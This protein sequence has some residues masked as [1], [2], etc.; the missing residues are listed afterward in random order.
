MDKLHTTAEEALT[1]AR[2]AVREAERDLLREAASPVEAAILLKARAYKA[3]CK[4]EEEA[5]RAFTA[6]RQRLST[7]RR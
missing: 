2:R 3:A 6:S 5:E 4:A 1:K 7:P